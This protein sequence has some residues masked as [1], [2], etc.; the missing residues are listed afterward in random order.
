MKISIIIPVYK[1]Q[2]IVRCLDSFLSQTYRNFEIICVGDNVQDESHAIIKEYVKHHPNQIQF[3]LQ[4][5]RGQG[6]ARNLGLSMS[7]GD[8]IMFCDADDYVE[9]TILQTM[10][11]SLIENHA[12][13]VC[14]GFDRSLPSGHV[15]S[16][17]MVKVTQTIFQVTPQNVSEL[18]F[19]FPAPW[20][21]LFKQTTIG[22]SRFPENPMSAYEDCIFFLSL[23]PKIK[24]YV[25]LPQIL[26]HYVTHKNSAV[27]NASIEKSTIFRNDL[28]NLKKDFEQA[29]V[30]NVYRP[31]LT[32]TAFIHVGIADV[33]RIAETTIPLN[34]FISGAKQ[35][36]DTSFDG[37]RN[38]SYRQG[39][40][41]TVRSVG[42]YCLKWLYIFNSFNVFIYLYNG[43]I[44]KLHIDM[45]W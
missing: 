25:I 5:G 24:K 36:L 27:T 6:G 20:G 9:Q 31:L 28:L 33:H 15:F 23:A 42:I 12:D 40:K 10:L 18:A 3:V 7:Q 13:F 34:N 37:W 8:Y 21:K 26:Y 29:G 22:D 19:V 17:E 39:K 14:C 1:S 2:D 43:L 45:K 4:E 35:F 11:N 38:I 44:K 30:L 32:L 16:K 41:I